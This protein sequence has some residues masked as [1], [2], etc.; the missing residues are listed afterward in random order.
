MQLDVGLLELTDGGGDVAFDLIR[1]AQTCRDDVRQAVGFEHAVP[2]E[3]IQVHSR[4][5]HGRSGR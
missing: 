5:C 1:M 3:R 2:G 4:G